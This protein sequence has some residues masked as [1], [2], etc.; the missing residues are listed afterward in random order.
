[1][2]VLVRVQRNWVVDREKFVNAIGAEVPYYDQ[3]TMKIKDVEKDE[4]ITGPMLFLAKLQIHDMEPQMETRIINTDTPMYKY[5]SEP[6]IDILEFYV[7]CK[8][9]E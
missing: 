6:F 8:F 2:K 9:Y 5:D 3:P 7:E 4:D 1:M